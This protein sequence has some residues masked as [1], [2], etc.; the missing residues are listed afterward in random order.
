MEEYTNRELGLLLEKI[1]AKLD[2]MNGNV[3]QNIKDI[4]GLKMWRSGLAAGISV[5]VIIV[6]PLLYFLAN[7]YF[8]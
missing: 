2:N 6:L 7:K 4:S 3:K 1:D 5:I 8:N